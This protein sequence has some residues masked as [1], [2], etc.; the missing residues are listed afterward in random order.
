M[1]FTPR[2]LSTLSLPFLL[3]L[4]VFAQTS[5]FT[6]QGRLTDNTAAAN[7]TYQMQFAIFDLAVA[8]KQLGSTVENTAV[9]VNNGVF[10]VQL[11]FGAAAFSGEERFLEVAVRRNSSE[12]YV[13]LVPRIRITSTPYSTR[14]A[15]AASAES[16]A[17]ADMATNAGQLGGVNAS[18]FVQ[19]SDTRLTDAR[20]PLPGSQS[21]IQNSTALQP[22]SNFHI[23]GNG[24]VGGS[25]LAAGTLLVDPGLR[26]VGIGTFPTSGTLSLS[27]DLNNRIGMERSTV[28]DTP[29]NSLLLQAGGASSGSNNQNGGTLWL[30]S[31]SSTGTGS[32]EIYLQ[33]ASGGASGA[34]TNGPQTRMRILG[35][36]ETGIGDGG[37]L[38][39]GAQL[40][41]SSSGVVN[42]NNFGLAVRNFTSSNDTSLSPTK[43]GLS[44]W[45]TQAVVGDV[46]GVDVQNLS[47]NSVTDGKRKWGIR[48]Q[49]TGGFAG[50]SGDPTINYGL[51]V[52]ALGADINYP[53]IFTGG[54]V[55]IGTTA[56]QFGLHLITNSNAGL[57]V[58]AN[59]PSG[60]VAS[61][62]GNGDF[63]IDSPGV[64]GGRLTVKENGNVG[65]GNTAPATKLQVTG[66]NVMISHPNSLIITSP[67]GACWFITVSDTGVLSTIPTPCP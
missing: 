49:S 64:D 33:T 25:F 48:V 29:G 1:S 65:I 45:N 63:K 4:S 9:V 57:R 58:Q 35:N 51:N 53:A 59:Q 36:G 39:A 3:A 34:Q 16:A 61:F 24:T 8:G 67:N 46:Y 23:S 56:P 18:E 40:G 47:T 17:T 55:G 62:G 10:T 7:G 14:A 43:I 13:T 32:S 19:T 60:A 22:S 54:N 31:G 5:A 42:G 44:V 20:N 28:P 6:Y 52:S 11:D 21:Y 30:Q 2:L 41:V 66:G 37:G 38:V 15:N 26:R 27:G 12:T 50:G